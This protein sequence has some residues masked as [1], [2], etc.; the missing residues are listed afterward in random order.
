MDLSVPIISLRRFSSLLLSF[1]FQSLESLLYDLS[2][3]NVRLSRS[4]STRGDLSDG[5]VRLSR[6]WSTRGEQILT[7]C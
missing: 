6:S 1:D 4:W 7:I 5:N 3:G 2:D